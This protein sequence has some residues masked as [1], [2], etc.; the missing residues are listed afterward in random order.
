MK[1]IV[2]QLK[3]SNIALDNVICV[4]PDQFITT[5][6]FDMITIEST[7]YKVKLTNEIEIGTIA[8]GFVPRTGHLLEVG[9]HI[10][11]EP[12]YLTNHPISPITN[13][14]LVKA[15]K[16]G[17]KQRLASQTLDK[18]IRMQIGKYPLYEGQ[19][20]V[21]R[22]PTTDILLHLCCKTIGYIG[23]KIDLISAD[24]RFSVVSTSREFKRKFFDPDFSFEQIGI[25]GLD[26]QLK[27]I[28]RKALT[29]RAF[30]FETIKKL[31]IK[32]AKGILLYGPPGVGKTL[33]ARKLG[34]LLSDIEPKVV[35]GPEIL[36]KFVGQ[37]EENIRMIF[38][39][40]IKDEKDLGDDSPMHIIIF[41]EID[42][43]CKTRGSHSNSNATFDSVVNQLLTM[44][45]GVHALNNIFIIAMTNR[46]ELLDPSLLRPGRIGI[47]IPI[48]LPTEKGRRQILGI[49][50][51][52]MNE[53]SMLGEDVDLDLM[54]TMTENYNGCELEQLVQ[55]A[56]SMALHEA[57]FNDEEETVSVCWKHLLEAYET[58]IPVM[59]K[60]KATFPV[61]ADL[62]ISTEVLEKTAT[63]IIKS[64]LPARIIISDACA[65]DR[66]YLLRY[67][68]EIAD[69]P[70]ISVI[71]P[72]Q[73]VGKDEVKKN[74]YMDDQ[75]RNLL[76]F[77]RGLLIVDDLESMI[78]YIQIGSSVS[79]SHLCLQSLITIFKSYPEE[80][81]IDI[82]VS[83]TEPTLVEALRKHGIEFISLK[84]ID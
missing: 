11:V 81:R 39:D 21:V 23:E 52:Q 18:C 24:Q 73:L 63:E 28:F 76:Q 36:N 32:H 4:H 54:A 45:D 15:I 33:I 20:L 69:H 44:I 13:L 6:L 17:T 34:N 84:P 67:L 16:C 59:V 51:S 68:S 35:S 77:E 53:N 70:Y 26:D 42:A 9:K 40:A 3:N 56:S 48:S 22:I 29:S 80:S 61:L 47:H 49:H 37:S 46:K 71:R 19:H 55:I 10:E 78:N 5:V 74:Q 12:F 38:E 58:I 66:S 64:P 2:I 57:L 79:Y 7:P 65:C 27:D 25:G 31:G 30:P 8:I 60:N 75:Y 14:T 83:C 41:D 50:T 62:S 72:E 43:I 82:V 1:L